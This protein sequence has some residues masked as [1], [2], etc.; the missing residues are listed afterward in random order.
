MGASGSDNWV[1][2]STSSG[3]DDL[4]PGVPTSVSF[5][6]RIRNF[7]EF[8]EP[9]RNGSWPDYVQQLVETLRIYRVPSQE[10]AGW[11]VDRLSSKALAALLNLPIENR[12]D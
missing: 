11:L 6:D 2:E 4:P 9:N 8:S 7:R 3:D 10:W 5:K 12:N 1:V